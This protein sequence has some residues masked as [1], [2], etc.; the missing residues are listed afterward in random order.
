VKL[1]Y[2]VSA[3]FT[4]FERSPFFLILSLK[5]DSFW[6]VRITI[7]LGNVYHLSLIYLGTLFPCRITI[8]LF[9]FRLLI[10]WD[11]SVG[12]LGIFDIS[13]LFYFSDCSFFRA[14]SIVCCSS[15]IHSFSDASSKKSY[16]HLLYIHAILSILLKVG[17][18]I[19]FILVH[20]CLCL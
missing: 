17:N 15:N 5:S 6:E 20:I 13:L 2:L 7:I 1:K 12:S 11:Q 9:L 19:L 18:F 10:V 3:W 14:A 8:L 16:G 4:I